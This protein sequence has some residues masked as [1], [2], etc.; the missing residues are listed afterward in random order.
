VRAQTDDLRVEAEHGAKLG[1]RLSAVL[2]LLCGCLLTV[3]LPLIPLPAAANR[4]ALWVVGCVALALGVVIWFVPWHRWR[5]EATLWLLLPT[6]VLIAL[7]NTF[8]GGDG[9][10]Y[11]PFFFLTFAWTGLV[12]RRGTSAVFAPVAAVAYLVPLAAAH[13]WDAV[14]ASSIVY[15]VP[16]GVLLGESIA[17]VSDRLRDARRTVAEREASFRKLFSENP[18][19]MWLY[20]RSNLRFIEVNAA[21]IAHYGY[22]RGEFAAM[23]IFDIRPASEVTKLRDRLATPG[24]DRRTTR[25]QHVLKDGRH[26]DVDVTAHRIEFA[27]HDATL[28]SVQDVTE[29]NRLEEELRHRAFHDSLTEL[30]NRSLFADRVQ[31]ALDL[32]ARTDAN[33][34]VVV[35]DVDGFKTINDSLGHTAGDGLLVEVG[36]RLRANLRTGDTAA[37][38]GGDEFAVLFENVTDEDE[39]MRRAERLLTSMQEPFA[40]SGK[41]LVVSASIGFACN[42]AGDGPEELI[43]NADIAMYLAKR[44]GK[45]CVRRF[46]PAMHDAAIERLELEAELRRALEAEEL[47]LHFQPTLRVTTGTVSGLEA[48]VRWQ[49]PTRGLLGP[50]E[51]IPVAEETGLIVDVGRWVLH[52]ACGQLRAW[53]RRHPDLELTVAV[54]VSTRQ[55]RDPHLVDDVTAALAAAALHPSRLVL[56]ITESVLLD[57]TEAALASLHRLKAIGVRL[58]IDDFGTGYSSLNYLRT[59]PID[60]VKIDKAFVDGVATHAE[61][62][63]LIE[64]ILRMASTLQLE[65]VAEGVET[66][67]Q[68]RALTHLGT[69]VVQGYYYSKPLPC[70]AVL[71]FLTASTRTERSA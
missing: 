26:I 42:R 57:D 49:H 30:A 39:I 35:L 71:P 51:F 54:N 11:A 4:L 38:L 3:A 59:L 12:H 25:A 6:F 36:E 17:W 60:I 45:A 69:D 41:S 62:T 23:T 28:V 34:A 15:V 61:S 65:T 48:L 43:R 8:A 21:A 18:Q 67:A 50:A 56:E 70:D 66:D 10:L 7:H 27:G 14:S 37:R 53:H 31:H 5:R 58:A 33:V 46:E 16:S 29:R 63:G 20:D 52:E 19:P 47:V 13:R 68:L 2:Y 22:T 1:G 9:Y 32:D 24:I 40:I 44:Q 64:A 55:L